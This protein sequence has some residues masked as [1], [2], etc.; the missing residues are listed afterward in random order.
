VSWG[1]D[2][3]KIRVG[4]R[5][6]DS[7]NGNQNVISRQR[8]NTK[9]Y[10]Q[11]PTE[12][13]LSGSWHSTNQVD[14]RADVQGV[15]PGDRCRILPSIA[16]PPMDAAWWRVRAPVRLLSQQLSPGPRTRLTVG[17]FRAGCRILGDEGR[18][19][20]KD[21]SSES[22]ND[23]SDITDDEAVEVDIDMVDDS[24][25]FVG[26]D[27][28]FG[29]DVGDLDEVDDVDAIRKENAELRRQLDARQA[30]KAT[31]QKS[32]T[33]PWWR[34]TIVGVAVVLAIF[35]IVASISAVWAKTTLQDE[36]QFVATLEPLPK[37]DAVATAI[38]VTVADGVVEAIGV[39]AWV[40]EKLPSEL[41]FVAAPLTDAIEGFVA[42]AAVEVIE[43]DAFNSVWV[44]TLRLTH[45]AASAVVSGNDRVLEAEGGTVSINLDEIAGQVIDRVEAAGLDVPDADLEL[46]SIVLYEDD[47][48]AAVQSLAT[49]IDT[50][51]WLLPLL[52][53]IFI[54][55]AI[56]VSRNRRGTTAVLGFGT[57]IG[58]ALGLI[59]LRLGRNYV[60][61]AIED[62]TKQEAAGAIWDVL[63]ERLYQMMWATLILALIIGIVA[64]FAGPG[65]R[66][67]RTRAWASGTI[68]RWREP[69]EESPNSFTDFVAEWKATIEVVAVAA[70]LMFIFLGP[71]PTGFSVLLT[72]VIVLVVV[73]AVEVLA[74]PDPMSGDD[75]AVIDVDVVEVD[76]TS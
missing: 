33:N 24:G 75:V 1:A 10:P 60:V 58:T 34:K 48:L 25:G 59:S 12:R 31:K 39:E 30:G 76:E 23:S 53:L 20:D 37:D 64:W 43:S 47:Q 62:A 21:K 71:S 18:N 44:A 28:E 55:V 70:G 17:A 32:T 61:N 52:A 14:G 65:P 27:D 41:E 15:L 36:D 38:S 66:A 63:L 56:G 26:A 73:V 4:L 35:T 22:N 11:R 40:T 6:G 46:G 74:V 42:T 68:L 3:V 72:A 29:V 2:L 16:H 49:A 57:F 8:R 5:A 19:M 69:V 67:T 7:S 9:L 13:R 51:G 45:K 50:I 54:L